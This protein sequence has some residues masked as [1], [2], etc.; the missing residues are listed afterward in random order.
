VEVNNEPI[1][2]V[3]PSRNMFPDNTFIIPFRTP[4][5]PLTFAAQGNNGSV[6]LKWT[7]PNI[8]ND[9]NY[10]ITDILSAYYRYRYYTVERRDIS[11]SSTAPWVVVASEI[12]IPSRENGGVAGY[13]TVYTVS[14]LVNEN[15]YQFR[16][17]LMIINDY[18][19]Q[20]AFSEWTHMSVIN[21]VAVPES[22]GNTVYPS[23]YPYKPGVPVLRFA[24]RTS[25][26][27]GTL[28]GLTVL[29][30]YPNYNGNADY[31]ECEIFYTPVGI[32]GAD[33][34]NIFDASNGIANIGDNTSILVG[35]K[36]VTSSASVTGVEQRINVVCKSAVLAYGFRIRILGRKTGLAEP[37]P[38]TLYSD[39]SSVDYIEI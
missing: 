27:T 7:L 15:N 32:V 36:I 5:S 10:Y 1:P 19:A 9:P 6:S 35:G 29:F 25:T 11:S 23:I 22:S 30:V 12:E 39:Y 31:Y 28:N 2:L 21:N 17:R 33:W 26:A 18:N 38:Y 16:V 37:Y 13:E 14:G 3:A 4:L 24:D 34:Y 8:I 20:R